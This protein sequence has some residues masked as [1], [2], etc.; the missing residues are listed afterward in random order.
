MFEDLAEGTTSVSH[1]TTKI[2]IGYHSRN[3]FAMPASVT[4]KISF[5]WVREHSGIKIYSRLLF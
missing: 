2:T 1:P 4:H 3:D 5:F